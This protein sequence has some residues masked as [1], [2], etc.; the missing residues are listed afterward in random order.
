[1]CLQESLCPR[2]Q[3]FRLQRRLFNAPENA[4]FS[5]DS[6]AGNDETSRLIS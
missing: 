2:L 1:M 5:K 4:W 6:E 3:A